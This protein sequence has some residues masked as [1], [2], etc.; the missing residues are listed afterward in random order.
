LTNWLIGW[1]LS[2][3]WIPTRVSIGMIAVQIASSLT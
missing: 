3:A 2:R 1:A